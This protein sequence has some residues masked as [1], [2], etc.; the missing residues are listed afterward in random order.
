MVVLVLIVLGTLGLSALHHDNVTPAE[1]LTPSQSPSAPAPSPTPTTAHD[2]VL[3]IVASGD[4]LPHTAVDTDAKTA[5]GSYDFSKELSGLDSWVQGGDLA[6]CHLEVPIAPEGT[7]VSGYPQFGAPVGIARDLAQQGWDG[8]SNASNHSMDRGFP[9]VRATLAA[10]DKAGLG[11]AGTGR[12]KAEATSPQL[13]RLQRA[14]QT[15]TV[16][17][18][19]ATF[20]INEGTSMP[21]GKPWSVEFLDTK[22]IVAQAKAARAAGA[23]VVVASIHDGDEYVT[24]PSADQVK[25]MKA[26]A[27]SGEIDFVIGAHTHVPQPIVKLSGGVHGRGMWVAYGVGN[28]LSNQSSACCV[29]QTGAGEFLTVTVTKPPNGPA[30]VT[31]FQWTPITDDTTG[32]HRVYAIPDVIS[33]AKGVGDLSQA[34]LK[35]RAKLVADAVGPAA[36]E[37]TTPPTSTGAPPTVVAHPGAPGA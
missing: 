19:A 27:K 18:I 36:T 16:A 37:R 13:Y 31:N 3:T 30:R 23:D 12:T 7:A 11:H 24:K 35:A 33:D 14:G 34:E 10:F 25:V 8:C 26:L 15:I 9:G 21:A 22:K 5:K 20:G 1:L 2:A 6:I 29:K 17:H 32:G 28:T 4:M